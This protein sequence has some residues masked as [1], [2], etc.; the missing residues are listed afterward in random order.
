MRFNGHIIATLF[1]AELRMV[2]RD[3]R[4]LITSI[5][6]PLLATPLIF[7]GSRWTLKKRESTLREAVYSYAVCFRRQLGRRG[8]TGKLRRSHDRRMCGSRKFPW[9]TP[10]KL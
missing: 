6:L 1:G 2:L 3:R 5:L 9:T 4:I 8:R 10:F 7:A